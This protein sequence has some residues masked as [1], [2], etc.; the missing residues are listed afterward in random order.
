MDQANLLSA[1]ADFARRELEQDSSGHDWWHI[2]RVTQMARRIAEEEGADAFLCE[3]A[4]L[5]HDVA[6]EK[7][8]ESEEAGMRKV[9]TWLEANEVDAQ[10]TADVLEIISTMSFKGGNR[11]PMRTLEGRIVQDA[12][13][14]DAI[15]AQGI[16]RV[17]AYSGAKGQLSHDPNLPPRTDMTAAEYRQG[18]STAINHFYEKLLLLKDNMNTKTA[19]RLAG[20]RHA[21]MEAFLEQF[22]AEWEG[23]R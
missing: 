11:P 14:L 19:K 23:Q 6:D 7:L 15:G 21:Y 8:N 17:F 1:A 3:L 20:E 10:T 9:R 5:L 13:R 16:A 12:D 18:K 4:A 22:Y 2:Y